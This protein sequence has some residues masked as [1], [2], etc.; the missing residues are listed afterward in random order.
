MT[1]Y[2]LDP[3]ILREYDVR[4]VVGKTLHPAD[5]TALGR[6]FGTLLARQGG[7]TVAVGYDGRI[8]SPELVGEVIAGLRSTGMDVTSVGLGPTPMLYYAVK[9]LPTDAGLMVTGS[10]NPAE[11]NGFK[12]LHQTGPVY[13]EA[14]MELGRISAD[15]QHS[16][17]AGSLTELDLRD[18]YVDRLMKDYTGTA[19]AAR[20]MGPGEWRHRRGAK[21]ATGKTSRP[22]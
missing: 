9:E 19:P 5:A 2:R 15:G 17:G 1:A 10:H 21:K 4:G 16:Q 12:M 7:R 11:Y 18:R 20:G 3:S 6:S 8:S 14:I 13:G 22:A